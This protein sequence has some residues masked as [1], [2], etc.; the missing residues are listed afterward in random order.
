M[1]ACR[2]PHDRPPH[3]QPP[4]HR[5]DELLSMLLSRAGDPPLR[6]LPLRIPLFVSG[7]SHC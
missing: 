3:L 5:I 2:R 4:A 1:V 6:D 7:F